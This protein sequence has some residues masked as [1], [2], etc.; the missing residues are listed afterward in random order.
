MDT[1]P[2]R[3]FEAAP[4]PLSRLASLLGAPP[5]VS[6]MEVRGIASLE[7][8]GPDRI[9][10]L[11]DRRYVSAVPRSS[12]GALLTSDALAELIGSDPR[13]L[14]VVE[15]PHR[16]LVPL[17]EALHP[18]REDEPEIHPTAVLGRGVKIGEAVRIGPYAVVESGARLGNRV[19]IGAHAVLGAGVQV[20]EDSVLHP[21]VVVYPNARIQA[22][23]TI[24]SGARIGVDGFGYVERDGAP[25]KVPQVGGCV[26]EADVE[27]G[28]NTTV[29]RGSIGETRIGRHSK[30]DNLVQVA[31]NV[32]VG[33]GSILAA[34][35]GIAGSSELGRGVQ[36]GGQA[37]I[38]GH[39]KV[40]DGVR[41]GGQTGIIGDVESGATVMGFPARPRS[42]YL[43]ATAAVA[44]LPGLTKRVSELER[45]MDA[46][47]EG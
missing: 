6:D 33:E 2:T 34:Q 46:S 40:G 9:G 11:A 21:H 41:I 15:D 25:R 29:D 23:V 47:D 5:P 45:R 39:L 27:I 18:A 42:E 32:R 24:H 38:G 30:L 36:A 22:R 16:A 10:L 7:E 31:H 12:A 1:F 13:P 35:V 8:A 19:R 44:R 3:R 43:R 17:L 26:I 37:G 20:G 14:L 28:A 4:M